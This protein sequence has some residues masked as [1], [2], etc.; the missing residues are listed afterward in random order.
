MNRLLDLF[1]GAGGAAMGYARAGFQVVGIDISPQPLYPFSFIQ[2]DAMGFMDVVDVN[3]FDIIHASPPCQAFG[4]CQ[5]MPWVAA[6][7]H[8]DLLTPMRGLL[9]ATSKPFIIENVPGAPLRRDLMLCGTMF[10]L[11]VF[12]HR[13]FEIYPRQLILTPPC[14]HDGTVRDG[15]YH[16]VV[17]DGSVGER[18]GLSVFP[19]S[20]KAQCAK[21][22]G[23]DWMTRKAMT[24]AIP[25]AYTE[26]IG[27]HAIKYML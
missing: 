25:P 9:L 3:A 4:S 27:R 24:Q 14:Q 20:T 15:E 18:K 19:Y 13:Y 16:C 5:N 21:A 8:T 26:Y 12:R 17:G 10:G 23:I 7:N 1:C 6:R 11:K 2:A 22:M